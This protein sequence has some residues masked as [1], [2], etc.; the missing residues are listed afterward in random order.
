M[1]EKEMAKGKKTKLR[2][3]CN[4]QLVRDSLY[5]GKLVRREKKK[6]AMC[7][8]TLY[9]NIVCARKKKKGGGDGR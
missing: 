2:N 1:K 4:M 8:M 7:K 6:S 9:P 5:S 3:P